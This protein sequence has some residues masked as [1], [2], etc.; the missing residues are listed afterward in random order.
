M[1]GRLY[2]GPG[3]T[4]SMSRP[5][6]PRGNAK[7]ESFM[8]TLK[9]EEVD[10]R[11]FE[12]I[13]PARRGIFIDTICNAERLHS[14]LGC[15]PPIEFETAIRGVAFG[16]LA[17]DVLCSPFDIHDGVPNVAERPA[18]TCKRVDIVGTF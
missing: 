8:K 1:R 18:L 2:A 16:A 5:G 11:S 9:T 15:C 10:G 7:A 12:N 6:N 4:V 13:E 14:V 17:V 3:I